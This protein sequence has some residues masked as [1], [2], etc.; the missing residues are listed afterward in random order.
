MTAF[1]L[2]VAIVAIGLWLAAKIFSGLY[3]DSPVTLLAAAL[4][5]GIV[6]AIVRPIAVI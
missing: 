1:F 2:R 3:F 4:L 5:L 6:N